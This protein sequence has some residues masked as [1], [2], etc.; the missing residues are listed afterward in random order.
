VR[1][2]NVPD[3]AVVVDVGVWGGKKHGG[4]V[5]DRFLGPIL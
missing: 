4:V 2:P 5:L 1:G 3:G